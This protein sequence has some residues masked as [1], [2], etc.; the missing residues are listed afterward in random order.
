MKKLNTRSVTLPTKQQV[1]LLLTH[2]TMTPPTLE[3]RHTSIC[4]GFMCAICVNR[5]YINFSMN[6]LCVRRTSRQSSVVSVLFHIN[7]CCFLAW[8]TSFQ[9]SIYLTIKLFHLC[10]SGAGGDIFWQH[11]LWSRRILSNNYENKG[12]TMYSTECRRVSKTMHG[13]PDLS[14]FSDF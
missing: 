7:G 14:P 1:P 4:P 2:F 6:P 3:Y 11:C 9:L 5:T 13:E 10:A 12:I 8:A